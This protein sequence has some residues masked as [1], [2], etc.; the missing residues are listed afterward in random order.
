M[1]RAPWWDG[2]LH[3]TRSA[4]RGLRRSPG[5]AAVV[6]VTLALCVGANAA[7]FSLLD[8]IFARTPSGVPRPEQLRRLWQRN[9]VTAPNSPKRG[10]TEHWSQ[11]EY[12]TVRQ[13]MTNAPR[14][15]RLTAF[16]VGRDYLGAHRD[17][18]EVTLTY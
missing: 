4:V 10:A 17:G 18:A 15:A 7:I 16:A 3:D 13:L 2:F 5:F 1:T 8:G 11:F 6:V 9:R 14:E 12:P